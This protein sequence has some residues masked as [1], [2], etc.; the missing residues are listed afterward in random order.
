MLALVLLSS[1]LVVLSVD[2]VGCEMAVA[3]AIE[4]EVVFS[5]LQKFVGRR[6]PGQMPLRLQ[7]RENRVCEPYHLA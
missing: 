3:I 7:Q 6:H 5:A 2:R 4:Q 1:A